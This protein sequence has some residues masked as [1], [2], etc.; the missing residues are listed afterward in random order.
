MQKDQ[1]SVLLEIL[2]QGLKRYAALSTQKFLGD[3]TGYVGLSD[4]GRAME[5]MRATV[6]SKLL[7]AGGGDHDVP[8]EFAQA[9]LRRH[10]T[11]Q[12][13]HCFEDLVDH[14][15]NAHDLLLLRQLEI[16]I[17]HQGTPIRAHLDFVLVSP[18]PVPTVRILECKSAQRL[19][20]ALYT[21]YETQVYGQ[22]G[23]LHAAWNTKAFSLR[24]A[25]GHVVSSRL[26]FPELC[27]ACLGVKLPKRPEQVDL[28][29]WV[30]CLSMTDGKAFGPYVAHPAMLEMCLKTASA[31][32]LH[33]ISCREGRS[34]IDSL[35][36][37]NGCHGLCS[38]CDWNADCPKFRGEEH[39]DWEG[40]LRTL[41]T[42]KAKKQALE[43]TIEEKEELIRTAYALSQ[44]NH[45]W[46]QAGGYRCKLAQQ[47]GRRGLDTERL[48]QEITALTGSVSKA[49]QLLARCQTRGQPTT[50]LLVRAM[51]ATP[52]ATQDRVASSFS[53]AN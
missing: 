30:L 46:I 14:A 13:G 53:T 20:D 38:Y 18:T 6:A 25:N 8:P 32:W 39:H 43:E 11:L 3:R 45:A 15:L 44:A 31:L 5:C 10:L 34:D 41:F 49:E 37:A 51:R 40:D 47:N 9:T 23:L 29:A 35:P 36:T 27:Q 19:P 50:R 33:C 24:D 4:V 26:T 22:V 42:L 52:G 7:P 2:S 16:E 1:A 21:S 48:R 12:R 28:Q 17:I